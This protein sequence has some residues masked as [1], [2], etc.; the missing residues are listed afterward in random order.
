MSVNLR[1]VT[2]ITGSGQP[3]YIIDG[4]IMS[5]DAL[6]GGLDVITNATGFGAAL[7]QGQ[8]SNRIADLNPNDIEDIQVLKGGSAAAVYGSKAAAGVI[9]ITTKKGQAGKTKIDVSQQTGFNSLLRKQ[10]T[11]RYTTGRDSATNGV[12][13]A[14][15]NG[16][17]YDGRRFI[18]TQLDS[19]VTANGFIDYED[20]F[21][22]QMGLTNE[23]TI[24]LIA[25][26]VL[27][28]GCRFISKCELTE[29]H[30]FIN[31]TRSLV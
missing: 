18:G 31:F 6:Q 4:V 5:N 1:G 11:L 14:F 29:Y 12:Q 17:T 3:L 13:A 16:L 7:P 20:V 24:K 30:S 25:K 10:G 8:P 22:G 26:N 9:I 2:T 15:P 19:L 28:F 21:Y 23:T 27:V